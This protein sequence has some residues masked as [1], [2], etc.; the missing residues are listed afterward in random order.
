MPLHNTHRFWNRFALG[1]LV[2]LVAGAALCTVAASASAHSHVPAAAL[3]SP[4]L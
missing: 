1:T 2:L 4:G 3:A